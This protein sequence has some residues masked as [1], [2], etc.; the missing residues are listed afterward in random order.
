MDMGGFP[1]DLILFGMIAAFLVLRLRSI[2]GRRTGFERPPAQPYQPPG[3]GPAGTPGGPIIEG[4][5]EPGE[6][7]VVRPVPDPASPIG[8]TLARMKAVDRNFEPAAFL[9]G[10]EQAFRIIVTA[11]AGGDRQALRNLTGED[12]YRS[13]DQAIAAREQAGHTQVSEIKDVPGAEIEQAELRGTIGQVAVRFVSDQVSLTKDRNGQPVAGA[14][15]VT[16]ITDIWT[17]ERD[18]SARDPTWRLTS[19]RGG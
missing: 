2:L 16:E 5:A 11:F 9:A 4:R 7:A 18:L 3:V 15:A 13:F 14:D 8:Q 12:V 6:P 19:V 1:V 17:F 10:A